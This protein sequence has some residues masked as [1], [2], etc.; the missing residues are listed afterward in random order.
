MNLFEG[1]EKFGLQAQNVGSLFEE[2]KK[3]VTNADG[4]KETVEEIKDQPDQSCVR[5]YRI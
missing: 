3:V 5:I 4:S 1:L 2:E